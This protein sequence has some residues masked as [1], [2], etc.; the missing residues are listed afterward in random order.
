M[1]Y[2]PD[3]Y[4]P[5]VHGK[6]AWM[7]ATVG[8]VTPGGKLSVS[9]NGSLQYQHA[10]QTEGQSGEILRST[11][12]TVGV[13]TYVSV[14]SRSFTVDG[15]V[16]VVVNI[17]LVDAFAPEWPMILRAEGEASSRDDKGTQKAVT[18]AVRL[19]LEK[20]IMARVDAGVVDEE[21]EAYAAGSS[22]AS[23]APRDRGPSGMANPNPTRPASNGQRKNLYLRAQR[24]GVVTEDR[25]MTLLHLI[26]WAATGGRARTP[27]E[28]ETQDGIVKTA[29][30]LAIY[31]RD[32][33]GATAIE[34]RL[35]AFLADNPYPEPPAAPAEEPAAPAEEPADEPLADDLAPWDG[36]NG[37]ESNPEPPAADSPPEVPAA[38]ETPVSAPAA[39]EELPLDERLARTRLEP[40]ALNR[41]NDPAKET[42][43]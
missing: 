30:A 40:D 3:K 6:V 35:E 20:L 36:K 27:D 22:S 16:L 31:G 24:A 7:Q 29:D 11:L 39:P 1:T 21:A 13:A 9:K 37:P 25:D 28:I 33:A 10:F 12:A 14:V 34:D 42:P 15:R 32:E 43:A 18:S 4:G 17:E 5:G 41:A 38:P 26:T 2:D 8:N 19:A 23:S